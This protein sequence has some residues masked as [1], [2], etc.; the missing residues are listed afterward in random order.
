MNIGVTYYHNVERPDGA[1]AQPLRFVV[2]LLF[3]R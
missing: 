1:A 2:T 3:P